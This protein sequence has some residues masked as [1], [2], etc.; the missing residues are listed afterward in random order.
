[1][2]KKHGTRKIPNSTTQHSDTTGK[3]QAR[4]RQRQKTSP[5]AT[6][7]AKGIEKSKSI[8]VKQFGGWGLLLGRFE[9]FA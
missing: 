8:R 6:P 9:F 1:M 4:P 5:E 7:K 3:G 2:R